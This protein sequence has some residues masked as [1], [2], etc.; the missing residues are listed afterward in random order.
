MKVIELILEK[1]AYGWSP[2]ELHFQH[3]YLTLGQI[4]S[5][6]AYLIILYPVQLLTSEIEL[7]SPTSGGIS[8]GIRRRRAC[9][10]KFFA[11][12]ERSGFNQGAAD[13]CASGAFNWGFDIAQL[14]TV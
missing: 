6:L 2:E 8:Q 4:Y 14:K 9:P 1:S 10:V 7:C 13:L 3:A 12:D 11:E 5:A